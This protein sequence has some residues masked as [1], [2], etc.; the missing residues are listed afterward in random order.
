MA[1]IN[2][3]KKGFSISYVNVR[4]LVRNLKETYSVMNG[5]DVIC[6][7]ETW[8]HD[9]I[10]NS[11][12]MFNGYK[13]FRQDRQGNHEVKHRG[14]GLMA[15]I[16]ENLFCFANI[17]PMFCK[18]SSNLEQLWIEICKP[19][20]KRQIICAIY[21]P[22]SGCVRS[23]IEEL[24]TNI[25]Q[26]EQSIGYELTI[27][28]DFNINYRKNTTPEYKALKEFER[29]YQL[30]QYIKSPTR[31]T[32]KVK[33]TIDLIL[34]NMSMVSEANVLSHM[35]ADHFP[36]YILKK[37]DRI[38]KSFVYT[39]GRSYKKYNKEIYQNL[40]QTNHKWRSFWIKTNDPN[41]LW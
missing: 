27:I 33:S 10:T 28:G 9:K 22:P 19:N 7:G 6:V 35:I 26:L 15:Y 32:N 31:V 11:Q 17:I 41:V 21:R 25:D 39:Y 8:L 36:I 13:S 20:F 29:T 12:M 14:G 37:K 1:T 34:S 24:S 5:F 40:I 16:K 4:S 2:N 18:I 30:S 23:F 38:D 3:T